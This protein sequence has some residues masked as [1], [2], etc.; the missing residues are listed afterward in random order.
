MKPIVCKILS[1]G[2]LLALVTGFNNNAFAGALPGVAIGSGFGVQVRVERTNAEELRKIALAG[3]SYLRFDMRWGDVEH[4][5]GIYNFSEFDTFIHEMRASKLKAVIILSGVSSLYDEKVLVPGGY[6]GLPEA[7]AAPHKDDDMQAF[8]RFA[9]AAVSRYGTADIIWEL[10]NEPDQSGFWPPKPDA[11]A[12]SRL[13]GMTCAAIRETAPDATVIGPALASLPD[14]GNKFAVDFL[15]TFLKSPAGSCINAVSIHP[16]RWE[17][18]PETLLADYQNKVLPF[19]AKYTPPGK[20]PLTIVSGEWGY[21][22][23]KA[24]KDQQSAYL[25]RTHLVN[26]LSGV[27][28]SIWYQWRDSEN[29]GE[30]EPESNFGIEDYAGNNKKAANEINTI[31]PQIK[32]AVIV[33]KLPVTNPL[34]YVVLIKQPAGNYQLIAWIGSD[35]VKGN[36]MLKVEKQNYPLS[37]QPQLINVSSDNPLLSIP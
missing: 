13:A 32:D 26:L 25:L 19:L 34:Y 8:V 35:K 33:R 14:L 17:E 6:W 18:P 7:T 28:L 27:P 24:S 12:F 30:K 2:L 3:F 31:L 36:E 29:K 23:A 22:T 15:G 11:V 1:I 21:T 20:A 4:Q 10:W 37:L 16:Y 5:K 9:A